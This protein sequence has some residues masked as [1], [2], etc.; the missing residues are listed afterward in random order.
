MKINVKQTL[1][2]AAS[3]Y[4]ATFQSLIWIAGLS[5]LGPLLSQILMVRMRSIQAGWEETTAFVVI[6]FFVMIILFAFMPRLSLVS[7]RLVRGI[8]TGAP[9][10]FKQAYNE[11]KGKYWTLIGNSLLVGLIFVAPTAALSLL[12]LTITSIANVVISALGTTLFYTMLPLIAYEANTSS[13]L[14]RSFRMGKKNYWRILA[15]VFITSTIFSLASATATLF[16]QGS[17]YLLLAGVI[18]AAVS[19][20]MFPITQMLYYLIYRQLKPADPQPQEEA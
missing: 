5:F 13:C 11:T 15:L 4:Q 7:M 19:F 17:N 20:F 1:K 10:P 16:L 3:K 18:F 14:K 6:G 9:V 8:A 2:E 12:R